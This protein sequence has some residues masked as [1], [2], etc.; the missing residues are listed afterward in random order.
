MCGAI[1]KN[2]LSSNIIKSYATGNET[3]PS[4][5]KW[6]QKVECKNQVNKI[7]NNNIC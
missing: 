7:T 1:M 4:K 6:K 3:I 2:F 5:V